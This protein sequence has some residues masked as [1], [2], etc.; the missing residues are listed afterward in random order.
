[1]DVKAYARL[2]EYVRQ[3]PGGERGDAVTA[4]FV[5]QR[6]QYEKLADICGGNRIYCR[7]AEQAF[8]R[9]PYSVVTL[10]DITN[11]KSLIPRYKNTDRYAL[12]ACGYGYAS[13]RTALLAGRKYGVGDIRLIFPEIDRHGVPEF[14]F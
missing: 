5:L 11:I 10:R 9:G 8:R 3:F 4:R 7:P 2:K 13:L 14:D 1:M 6:A 12:E